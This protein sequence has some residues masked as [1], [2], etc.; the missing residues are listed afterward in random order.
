MSFEAVIGLALVAGLIAC[1]PVTMAAILLAAFLLHAYCRL[2]L[3]GYTVPLQLPQHRLPSPASL[4]HR[5]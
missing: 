4:R 2:I 3:G 1:A 5:A